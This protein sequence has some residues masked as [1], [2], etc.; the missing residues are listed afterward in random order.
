MAGA[1]CAGAY[2]ADLSPF[3]TVITLSYT[4]FFA[5]YVAMLVD[6]L[7]G[8][9]DELEVKQLAL[10]DMQTAYLRNAEIKETTDRLNGTYYSKV[11]LA[12]VRDIEDALN[13]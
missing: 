7:F 4:V 9:I 6:F 2:K 5:F 11:Y 10:A 3:F 13:K 1:Y 12:A 8:L